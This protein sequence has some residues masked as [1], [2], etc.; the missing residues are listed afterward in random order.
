MNN[1][2]AC[3][4]INDGAWGDSNPQFANISHFTAAANSRHLTVT[5]NPE[6][7]SFNTSLV[8]ESVDEAITFLEASLTIST[9]TNFITLAAP[10]ATIGSQMETTIAVAEPVW[11]WKNSTAKLQAARQNNSL[12]FAAPFTSS[13][14]GGSTEILFTA[15]HRNGSYSDKVLMA[16]VFGYDG[17]FS[18]SQYQSLHQKIC[19][20]LYLTPDSR[21]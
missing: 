3:V 7:A 1:S 9:S 13:F 8:Y 5:V 10:S 14:A 18:T 11:T 12:L 21:R 20:S 6:A 17:S 4:Q 19:V 16:I 2:L 15:K